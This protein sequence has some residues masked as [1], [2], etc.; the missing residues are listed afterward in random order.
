MIP[1]IVIYAHERLWE[2]LFQAD[3]AASGDM[4]ARPSVALDCEFVAWG[5]LCAVEEKSVAV[6]KELPA[7]MR[8]A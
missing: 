7:C 2:V 8:T 1:G 6:V 4:G 3:I 5:R